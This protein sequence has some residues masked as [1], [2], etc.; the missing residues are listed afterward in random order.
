MNITHVGCISVVAF[1]ALSCQSLENEADA[2]GYEKCCQLTEGEALKRIPPPFPDSRLTFY[3]EQYGD[4]AGPAPETFVFKWEDGR[5][6]PWGSHA[7]GADLASIL[8]YLTELDPFEIE[9]DAE[10]KSLIIPGDLVVDVNAT[11]EQI[12]RRLQEIL[13]HE[14]KQ[15]LRLALR[16]INR[17]VYVARG[18]F[19]FT[20]IDGKR[21][22]IEIYGQELST[23]HFG[24]GS[25]D[26]DKLLQ[27]VAR[28]IERP[29]LNEVTSPPTERMTWYYNL[30]YPFTDEERRLATD[31]NLVLKN[32]SKQTG[33][34]FTKETRL[35][36]VLV[37]ERLDAPE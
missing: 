32:L 13:H 20:S 6:V 29:V 18:N 16:R 25:G 4:P 8:H 2:D 31:P 26:L 33:L 11:R 14:L 7:G 17:E 1:A 36:P 37:V 27:W 3:R 34:E 5:V 21:T 10:L 30:K 23:S 28:W 24:R 15:N 12:V 19:K 9:G 22:Q 35:M